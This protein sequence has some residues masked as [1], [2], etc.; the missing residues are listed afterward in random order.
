MGEKKETEQSGLLALLDKLNAQGADDAE[1]TYQMREYLSR[2]ARE[3]H[4]PLHGTFELTPLCNL[5]CKMCYVHLTPQQLSREGKRLLTA[6]QWKGIMAQAIEAGMLTATLT[7]GEALTYPAFDEL[8][9]YLLEHGVGVTLKSN[10][11]LL[12]EERVA[13]FR[14][15]PP[16]GIQISLYGA[17]NDTYEAVTGMRSFDDAIGGIRRVK[18][19]GIP[20]EVC[21]TPSRP[22][23]PGMEKL[24][25][26]VDSLDVPIG[27][28]SMLFAAREETGRDVQILQLSLDEYVAL[29]KMRADLKGRALVPVPEDQLPR[30]GGGSCTPVQGLPCGGGSSSFAVHWN[31]WMHPCLSLDAIRFD[32]LHGSFADGWNHI[33]SEVDRCLFPGECTGCAYQGIC[34]PCIVSH[35]W[36]GDPGHPNPAFCERSQRMFAEGLAVKKQSTKKEI[37]YNEESIP[38]TGC[39][40]GKF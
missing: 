9:L 38:K 15:H 25:K 4:V 32:V 29:Y 16:E 23:L 20:L 3:R 7:G 30:P 2:L 40:E 34:T 6:E 26:L 13:F 18:E 14:K 22:A 10:G 21:I 28:S 37:D 17:D 27:I 5:G 31:G 39:E 24:L 33:R 1:I 36:G 12:T 11:I 8:Y 19:A 35:E